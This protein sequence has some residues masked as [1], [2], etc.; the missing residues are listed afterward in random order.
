[1]TGWSGHRTTTLRDENRSTSVTF[2]ST[3]SLGMVFQTTSFEL[4]TMGMVITDVKSTSLEGS[5][6][7]ILLVRSFPCP[8]EPTVTIG[9]KV[10]KGTLIV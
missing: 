3:I 4:K 9:R 6:G 8:R 1:M 5:F 2:N 7:D 10:E